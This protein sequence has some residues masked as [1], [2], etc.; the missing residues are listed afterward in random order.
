M[1]SRPKAEPWIKHNH[2]LAVESLALAPTWLDQKPTANDDCFEI[3]LPGFG[4]VLLFDSFD[5]DRVP[6]HFRSQI[7][8]FS[9][10][11]GNPLIQP[12]LPFLAINR[13][14]APPC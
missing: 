14:R 11:S 12:F 13:D 4:P 8:D 9:Q 7:F 1:L 5:S 2:G 6:Y 10:Q 3:F